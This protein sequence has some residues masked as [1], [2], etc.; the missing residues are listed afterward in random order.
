MTNAAKRAAVAARKYRYNH[1]RFYPDILN[2]MIVTGRDL[3]PGDRAPP[4]QMTTTDGAPLTSADLTARSETL[5][6]IFGSRTCPVTESAAPGLKR[7]HT[8]Y[9]DQ[10]RFVMV[11]VREAH[12]GVKIPQPQTM[13]TKQLHAASLK[14]H[15]DLPFEVATDDIDGSFHR[16]LGARPN[17]A[18]IFD[19]Y[20]DIVFRAQWANVTEAI[21]SAM[22]DIA[23]G[24]APRRGSVTNTLRAV[25]RM[26]GHMAPVH[27]AAGEGAKRDTWRVMPPLGMM[28]ALSGLFFFLPR[29]ERGL[30]TMVLTVA[31]IVAAIVATARYWLLAS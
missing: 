2:D 26:I 31:L 7:L 15:L 17:S 14:A 6:L 29:Q 23:T 20:G 21:E 11:N 27:F 16:V 10:I 24:S 25:A 22:A 19:P 1:P 12:P 30:P 18:F 8:I 9:G 4:F 5:F 28:M 3:G 13:E